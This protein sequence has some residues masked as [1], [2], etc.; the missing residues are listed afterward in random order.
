MSEAKSPGAWLEKADDYLAQF[1]GDIA[2]L[3]SRGNS[4]RRPYSTPPDPALSP[5]LLSAMSFL[6]RTPS[7]LFWSVPGDR[8]K[9]GPFAHTRASVVGVSVDPSV[10]GRDWSPVSSNKTR[11]YCCRTPSRARPLSPIAAEARSPAVFTCTSVQREL[12][13]GGPGSG[14]RP[15][16]KRFLRQLPLWFYVCCSIRQRRV[17]LVLLEL[18]ITGMC[19][20][21]HESFLRDGN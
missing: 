6:F 18:P 3:K 5:V 10:V 15:G 2:D 17:S 7:P 19:L 8:R 14:L 11:G 13:P 16:R 1:T 20:P 12:T 21:T 4:N 9:T